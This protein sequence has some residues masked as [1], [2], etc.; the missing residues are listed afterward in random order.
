[1]YTDKLSYLELPREK[2][3]ILFVVPQRSHIFIIIV[4]AFQNVSPKYFTISPK[5]CL[6]YSITFSFLFLSF[7]FFL[8]LQFLALS[9]GISWTWLTGS[10]KEV[11]QNST[12]FYLMSKAI[13]SYTLRKKA[14]KKPLVQYCTLWRQD[15]AN[16]SL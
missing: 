2:I 16:S 7:N 3:I 13:A 1:L 8:C 10:H 9:Y 11:F 15:R 6:R 12:K 5:S 4:L 14:P